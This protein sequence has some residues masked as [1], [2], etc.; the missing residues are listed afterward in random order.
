M[1]TLCDFCDGT[2]VELTEAGF[3]ESRCHVCGGSGFMPHADDDD[4]ANDVFAG[5]PE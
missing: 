4:G 3:W 2:G 1:D 5:D